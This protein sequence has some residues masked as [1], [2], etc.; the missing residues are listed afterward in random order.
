MNS[1]TDKLSKYLTSNNA[2]ILIAVI[3]AIAFMF[4]MTI[5]DFGSM[6]YINQEKWSIYGRMLAR[7]LVYYSP[8]LIYA[9]FRSKIGR[10]IKGKAIYALWALVFIGYPIVLSTWGVFASRFPVLMASEL[11]TLIGWFLGGVDIVTS[12]ESKLHVK[13]N[14]SKFLDKYSIEWAVVG[15]CLLFAVRAT[16]GLI[17]SHKVDSSFWIVFPQ[18]LVT[19][20]IF[21]LFYRI[22]HYFLINKIY[23]QKGVIYYGAGF[24]GLMILFFVPIML[25][26]FLLPDLKAVCRLNIGD[27]W[28]G[29]NPPAFFWTIYLGVITSMMILTIPLSIVVQWLLQSRRISELQNENAK[30]ELSLLK[31]QINPHFFFNTLNNVYAMSLTNDAKTSES[32]LQLSDLMRYTIYKGRESVVP[33]KEE[34][35]YLEDYLQLMKMRVADGLSLSFEKNIDQREVEVAPLLFI[36]LIENAFKH[37]VEKS[38]GDSF[39]DIKMELDDERLYFSCL[40][41]KENDQQQTRGGLGLDNLSRRLDLLYPGKYTLETIDHGDRYEAQLIIQL[42]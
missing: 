17:Q 37:G 16:F 5:A 10:H 13:A 14:L 36:I 3:I 9:A 40:N 4:Q 21:Y 26:Y 19:A 7:M 1:Y 33:L 24:L 39:I 32:I 31:Q 34:V 41:S 42:S 20:G 23:R 2:W 38:D 30:T 11:L 15:L 28:V 22:N 8:L 27:K 18:V 29:P 25:T 12:P 6:V 35:K